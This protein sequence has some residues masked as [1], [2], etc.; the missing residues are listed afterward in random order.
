M[1]IETE[2]SLLAKLG[3]LVVHCSELFSDDGHYFDKA[4][5]DGI[6]RDPEVSKFVRTMAKMSLVPVK[7]KKR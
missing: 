6:I 7:R 4:A 2:L 5:V 3:S 1:K